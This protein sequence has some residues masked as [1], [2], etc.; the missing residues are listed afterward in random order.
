MSLVLILTAA[1]AAQVATPQPF[2]GDGPALNP[3]PLTDGR[4]FVGIEV[5]ADPVLSALLAPLGTLP[6]VDYST[7]VPLLPPP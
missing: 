1:Q 4:Y 2:S 3:L 7:I 5:L 6:Q